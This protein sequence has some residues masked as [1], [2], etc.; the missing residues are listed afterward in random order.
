[1]NPIFLRHLLAKRRDLL[2]VT[3]QR[4]MMPMRGSTAVL[5]S[6]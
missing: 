4:R 6:N 2:V 5:F 1:M 3:I